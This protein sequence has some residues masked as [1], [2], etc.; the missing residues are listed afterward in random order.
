MNIEESHFR[1][2]ASVRSQKET[3]VASR[4]DEEDEAEEDENEEEED[5]EEAAIRGCS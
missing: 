1:L 2:R 4:K 3:A 5:E